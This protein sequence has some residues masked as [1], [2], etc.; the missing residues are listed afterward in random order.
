MLQL[1]GDWEFYWKELPKPEEFKDFFSETPNYHEMPYAWTDILWKQKNLSP[2]GY[3]TFHLRGSLPKQHPRLAIL[4]GEQGTA[5]QIFSGRRKVLERGNVAKTKQ[6]AVPNPTGSFAFLPIKKKLNLVFQISNYHHRAGGPWSGIVIGEATT[7]KNYWMT[8]LVEDAFIGGILLFLAIYH[9]TFF[10]LRRRDRVHILFSLFLLTMFVRLITTGNKILSV[11]FPIIPYEVLFRL[12]YL[13]FYFGSTFLYHFLRSFF[14]QESSYW[15]LRVMYGISITCALSLFLDPLLA[16][17]IIPFYQILFLIKLIFA[18]V[19]IVLA[20]VRRRVFS[21]LISFGAFFCM[22]TAIND[23]LH[24][25][26]FIQTGYFIQYGVLLLVSTETLA[27]S[28]TFTKAF[29][30]IESMKD[31]LIKINTAYQRFIPAEFLKFLGRKSIQDIGLG[32]QTQK[33]MTILFSDIRDFTALSEKMS[34]DEN[35]YF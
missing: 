12:E 28:M 18:S 8:E 2:E 9:F 21:G 19:T 14:P 16:S 30:S 4:T 11:I 24:S 33:T 17:Q 26:Q 10:L 32:D 23:I 27:L 22:V 15:A 5:Y 6:E 29:H 20:I 35:F 25:R 1:D 34:P 31:D 7:V 13:G 3:A